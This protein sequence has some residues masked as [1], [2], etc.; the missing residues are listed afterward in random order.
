MNEVWFVYP[1]WKWIAI[2]SA[3]ILFFLVWKFAAV[4]L[5]AVRIKIQKRFPEGS[6]AYEF[7]GLAIHLPFAGVIAG[8]F[9]LSCINSLDIHEGA[10]HVLS[11]IMQFFIGFHLIRLGL[12]GAETA[13]LQL[14]R[15]AHKTENTLDDQ[16]AP[17]VTKTLKL[18]VVVIG[19]LLILQNTG[20]NVVSLVAGL[21][22]GGLAL[23]LAAQDTVSNV[24]G[25]VTIIA[26][27]P[28]QVGD[29]V[30]IGDT[31]GTVED[32]G[33]RSTRIRT[34][35]R[36]LVTLPNST[37]A[38]EKIEN[39]EKRSLRP[40]KHNLGIEY[41][42]KPEQLA[43][44][45]EQIRYLL[46]RNP[47]VLKEDINVFFNQFGDSALNISVSFYIVV[48]QSIDFM[49][50]QQEILFDIMKVVDTCGLG[51]A[52][53]TQTLHVA[54]FLNDKKLGPSVSQIL[55]QPQT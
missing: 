53:P 50:T 47:D 11:N 33:F 52:F 44:V 1:N 37:V 36:S 4:S 45:I 28:F 31:E 51:F 12:I 26:D 55:P 30:K 2:A 18:L 29:W 41:G 40:C 38:K 39:M 3:F 22:I 16:L 35:S 32:L 14:Q 23:A 46:S 24:F 10:N 17:L 9:L 34:G 6:F 54:S 19:V 27:R 13:G 42:A 49:E 7:F 48:D 25:S 21:G 5:N 20:V 43:Q 15:W 8:V